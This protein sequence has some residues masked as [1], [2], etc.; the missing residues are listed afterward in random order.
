MGGC[1]IMGNWWCHVSV[2]LWIK[3]DVYHKR[4]R[5]IDFGYVNGGGSN[6][7]V[8][9]PG[10]GNSLGFHTKAGRGDEHHHFGNYFSLNSRIHVTVTLNDA[11][12]NVPTIRK[13]IKMSSFCF[14]QSG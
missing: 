10:Y 8:A 3:L 12:T 11:G 2:Y 1:R 9:V 7:I 13:P 14:H 6:I 4:Q 5:I